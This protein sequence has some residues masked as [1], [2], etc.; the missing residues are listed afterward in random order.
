MKAQQY[1]K[2]G[3]PVSSAAGKR[4]TVTGI[5]QGER[6]PYHFLEQFLQLIF[7]P[8]DTFLGSPKTPRILPPP[9][10]YRA[11]P[12]AKLGPDAGYHVPDP[13][14]STP[15]RG[16]SPAIEV[17]TD[18]RRVAAVT[19]GRFASIDEAN[20]TMIARGVRALF[21]IDDRH[22]VWGIVTA[23]DVLGEKPVQITQQRGIRHD[24]V[25]VRDIMTAVDRMEVIDLADVLGARVGDVVATLKRS[26]R[27]HALVVDRSWQRTADQTQMVRGIFSL[28]QIARQL[29]ITLQTTEIG[30]TFAE[31]AAAGS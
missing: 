7:Q 8:R 23:R 2:A 3:A 21:V 14:M 19:I 31:I 26:G 15:V 22:R 30:R 10:Q 27:Q 25:L 5:E 20:H 4:P 28:T 13:T 9:P 29:G 24:E 17:M 1:V 12:Q 6:P 18:L 16:E 11:L